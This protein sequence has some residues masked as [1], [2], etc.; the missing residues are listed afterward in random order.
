M[1][2]ERIRDLFILSLRFNFLDL[3]CLGFGR[4]RRWLENFGTKFGFLAYFCIGSSFYLSIKV[5]LTIILLISS[6]Y[7]CQSSY[8]HW[9]VELSHGFICFLHCFVCF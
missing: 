6:S 8:L 5:A 9:I 1:F 7:L 4:R 2:L 3:K